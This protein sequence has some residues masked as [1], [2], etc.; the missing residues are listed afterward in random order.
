[1]LKPL[2]SRSLATHS[3]PLS[4]LENA[5]ANARSALTY[6]RSRLGKTEKIVVAQVIE[7]AFRTL[8]KPLPEPEVLALYYSILQDYPED[9]LRKATKEILRQLYGGRPKPAD[10]CKH[11]DPWL[12]ERR[13]EFRVIQR[14]RDALDRHTKQQEARRAEE[15][16]RIDP[17]VAIV[18][19][20]QL[21]QQLAATGLKKMDIDPT[22]NQ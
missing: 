9:L 22:D 15:L 14:F 18:R 6:L 13:K 12:E 1:M 8:E 7:M 16:D 17:E 3:I 5:G 4:D 19:L 20:T 21:K 2:I 10:W 11:M